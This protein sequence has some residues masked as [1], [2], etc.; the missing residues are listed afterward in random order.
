MSQAALFGTDW[1]CKTRWVRGAVA[2]EA[3]DLR[4]KLM[5]T[6]EGHVTAF[7]HSLW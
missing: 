1:G 6:M 2:D 3:V 5:I 7:G 4:W